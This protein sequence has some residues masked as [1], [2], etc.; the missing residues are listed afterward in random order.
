MNTVFAE[1]AP[2]QT[3]STTRKRDW[4]V[5]LK[6]WHER[7]FKLRS[8]NYSCVI[9]EDFAVLQNLNFTTYVQVHKEDYA[10]VA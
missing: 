7:E 2:P 10:A 5:A 1:R 3:K 8:M 6:I 9:L 4:E